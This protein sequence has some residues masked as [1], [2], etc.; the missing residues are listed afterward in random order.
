MNEDMQDLQD[1][2]GYHQDAEVASSY[3]R[4]LSV[5]RGRR[6]RL[7]PETIFVMGAISHRY[8]VQARELRSHYPKAYRRV[9]GKRWK[10]LRSA[11]EKARPQQ[12]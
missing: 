1:V 10:K 3:L 2:L 11:M 7:P 4:G 8:E 6:R 12:Q 5:A 9:V